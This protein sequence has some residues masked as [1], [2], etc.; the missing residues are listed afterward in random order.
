MMNGKGIVMKLIYRTKIH[1]PNKYERFHNEYYQKGDIIEKY[2]ISSTRVPGRLEKG[3]TRRIDGEHLSASWHIQDPNMPQWLKQYI[4]N[5]SETH[6]GDLINELQTD[7]YRVHT[8]DDKPLLI[9]K[10]KIVKVFINQVWIDIIHLI[11][12]YYNKKKVTGKLLEQFEKDWLDLNVSY[13][14]L[15]DKQEEVNLLKKNEKYDKYYQKFYE[16]YNS[17]NAAGELNRFLLG[18][19]SNTKGTEK[20]YFVQLLDKVQKQDVTPEFYADTLA[21]IFT[22]KRSKIH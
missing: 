2:T 16:S 6:I 17:E 22:R 15:L 11:K 5:T 4:V 18:V 20:E 19:I 13:Q 8:C 10:D 7:G 21:K 1:K 9:F 14:Q 3:E 12:L